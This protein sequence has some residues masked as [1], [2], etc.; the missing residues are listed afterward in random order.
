M[1]AEQAPEWNRDLLPRPQD[2][3]FDHRTAF[4][5][6]LRS[7]IHLTSA[8]IGK[9]VIRPGLGQYPTITPGFNQLFLLTYSICL[10]AEIIK[11]PHL[12]AD[13]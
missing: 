11:I 2:Q 10:S 13:N 8:Q 1:V 6:L 4:G 7:V 5:T 12:I 3:A 9:S